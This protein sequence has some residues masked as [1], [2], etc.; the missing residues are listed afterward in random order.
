MSHMIHHILIFQCTLLTYLVIKICIINLMF[1]SYC[2]ILFI[3]TA[4]Y[5]SD[6]LISITAADQTKVMQDQM[7]GAAMAMPQ[8]PTKAFK[9]VLYFLLQS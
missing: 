7:S 5:N 3:F 1:D 8:D 2:D 6:C 9:V 4:V